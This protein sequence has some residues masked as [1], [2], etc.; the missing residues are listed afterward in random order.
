M[1]D[2]HR[3]S[4][5]VAF[6][7]FT[8]FKPGNCLFAW[9]KQIDLWP[10]VKLCPLHAPNHGFQNVTVVFSAVCVRLLLVPRCCDC[11][12]IMTRSK[13]EEDKAVAERS[14]FSMLHKYNN[15]LRIVSFLTWLHFDLHWKHKAQIKTPISAKTI[16][17][18]AKTEL[19]ASQC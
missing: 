12:K 13:T 10:S 3:M 11:H 7:V 4:L 1:L 2:V 8:L 19:H 15:Y 6:A 16:R 18:R 9:E 5:C 17:C 14:R